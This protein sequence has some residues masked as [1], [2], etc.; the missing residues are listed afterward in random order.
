MNIYAFAVESGGFGSRDFFL[1]LKKFSIG[2]GIC[3]NGF[4][5]TCFT[6]KNS[7]HFFMDLITINYFQML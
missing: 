6:S 5:Y 7:I 3:V 1:M 4:H 2:G